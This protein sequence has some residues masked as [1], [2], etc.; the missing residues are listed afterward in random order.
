MYSYEKQAITQWL[1]CNNLSP[2]QHRLLTENLTLKNG[3]EAFK[4]KLALVQRERQMMIDLE[5]QLGSEKSWREIWQRQ[6]LKS[7]TWKEN[8]LF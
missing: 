1:E 8:L 5:K 2:M 6:K 7:I 4:A 3:I